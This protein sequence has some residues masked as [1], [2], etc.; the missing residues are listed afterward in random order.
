MT[1]EVIDGYIETA[2]KTMDRLANRKLVA[3]EVGSGEETPEVY[4]NG[5]GEADLIIDDMHD[6]E[7]LEIGNE[8]GENFSE[9][10]SY[11]KYPAV[12]PHNK[13]I[14]KS[15]VFEEGIQN[16]RVTGR[17]GLF[18]TVPA[19]LEYACTVITAGM[20]GNKNS[21]GEIKS[22]SIGNYSVS[23]VSESGAQDFKQALATLE[24]YRKINF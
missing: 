19:D 7:K 14:L 12:A 13:L 24:T 17:V 20:I 22:E 2:S 11:I 21:A 18:D 16:V 6:I 23:Y 9:V 1:D 10:T 8:H 5:Q 15:G 4:Y 3:D